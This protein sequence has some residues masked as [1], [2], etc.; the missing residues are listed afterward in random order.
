MP[1]SAMPRRLRASAAAIAL[2]FALPLGSAP[3]PECAPGPESSIAGLREADGTP[4][5]L[6]L[7]QARRGRSIDVTAAPYCADNS[8]SS[9]ARP[10]IEAALLAARSG[11]ELYFPDGT[12]RLASASR[13]DRRANIILASGVSLRGQSREGTILK[14]TF[15]DVYSKRRPAGSNSMIVLYGSGVR[16]LSISSMTVSSYWSGELS[17]DTKR[18]SPAHGGPDI[19]ILLTAS[20]ERYCER[21]VVEDVAVEKFLNIGIKVDRGCRD[22]LVCRCVARSAT[23]LG[24]GGCGY[25]FQLSGRN[26]NSLDNSKRYANPNSGGLD[27]TYWNAILSCS[28]GDPYIRHG[29]LI[30]YWAHNNLVAD[31]VFDAT[32]LDAIDLHGE[33]EYANE[34]RN[35]TVRNVR[36]GAAVG[37]GNSGGGRVI[38]DKS[39]PGNL[40]AGNAITNCKEGITVRYGSPRVTIAG[41]SIQGC[42]APG[43]IGILL[44]FAPFARVEG[45]A[46]R[47]NSAPNFTGIVFVRDKAVGRSPAGAP[48]GCAILGNAILDNPRG[49][50]IVIYA[51]ADGNVFSGNVAS[52][53]LDDSLP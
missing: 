19:C 50:A 49:R 18:N 47:D 30:Q 4:H 23:D 14:T 11:D 16:D 12:Y 26:D 27:D 25:G 10:A 1:A 21:I 28:N 2:A 6:P 17:L 20:K 39:G 5:S 7:P 37:I 53:N 36:G 31:C 42:E 38:H 13:A 32:G 45:N 8:G 9:D 40:V 29:V 15:D 48:T 34:I 22:V 24:G 51:Q 43:C 52:G 44:G 46:I 33:D 41:N 3:R 35:N